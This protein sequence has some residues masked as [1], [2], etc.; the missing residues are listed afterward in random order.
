MTNVDFD[1]CVGYKIRL[2]LFLHKNKKE[3][4]KYDKENGRC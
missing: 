3:N 4:E 1:F 2:K